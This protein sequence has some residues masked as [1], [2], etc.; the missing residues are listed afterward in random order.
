MQIASPNPL[1]RR[2]TET[3][4][5]TSS[6]GV[7]PST[8]KPKNSG[9]GEGA[10]R[11]AHMHQKEQKRCREKGSEYGDEQT[12]EHHGTRY[13]FI[14]VRTH[15]AGRLARPRRSWPHFRTASVRAA[16]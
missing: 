6:F 11:C 13:R 16:I 4:L 9:A 12:C 5:P 2:S 1:E 15:A 8:R 10:A 7:V 3:V 14:G